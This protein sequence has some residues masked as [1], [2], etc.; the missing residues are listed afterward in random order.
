MDIVNELLF[1]L[2]LIG[3]GLG[4]TAAFGIAVV[5]SRMGAAA[6]EQRPLLFSV[7]E[8][9]SML[10]RIGFGTLIV[11]GPLIAWLKY[12]N[13]Y[14]AFGP[15]FIAKMVTV[16]LLLASV[17]ASG[18]L[19]GRAQGGD[20]GAAQTLPRLGMLNIVLLVLIVLFAV[21]TFD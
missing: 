9:L 8:R 17:I 3:L 5:G 18:V 14:G 11:T 1:W 7:T 16:V 15:W 20:V 19:G 6:P 21:L 2:H 10:G 12:E 4:A 13:E